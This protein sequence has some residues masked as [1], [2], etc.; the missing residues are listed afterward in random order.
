MNKC[1]KMKYEFTQFIQISGN[2]SNR[3][4]CNQ[5]EKVEY[6]SLNLSLCLI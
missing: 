3:R 5:N 6:L 1:I 2:M 4:Y